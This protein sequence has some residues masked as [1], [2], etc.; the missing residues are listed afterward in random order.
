MKTDLE[1]HEINHN[2][3]RLVELT[4]EQNNSNGS[5]GN[6]T[7]SLSES[8]W[9]DPGKDKFFVRKTTLDSSNNQ[10]VIFTDI[11]GNPTSP[12][13]GPS[14]IG[15]LVPLKNT[16]YEL[17]TT[18]YYANATN[19]TNGYTIGDLISSIRIIDTNS[20]SQINT[21]VINNNTEQQCGFDIAEMEGVDSSMWN[22]QNL[23]LKEISDNTL[24]DGIL[25]NGTLQ[26]VLN[27]DL[28]TS[29]VNGWFDA[30]KFQSATIQIIN[31]SGTGSI[32]FEQ[33][34]DISVTGL[35]LATVESTL[36]NANPNIAAI[37]IAANANRIFR[38]PINSKYIRVRVSTAFTST[39][40]KA[41]GFFSTLPFSSNNVNVQQAVASML[42]ATVTQALG[43]AA[44]RWFAQ[45]SDGTNSPSIKAASVAPLATDPALVVGLNPNMVVSS[46]VINSLATTNGAVVKAT[47]ATVF[48]IT[49]S[50]TSAS[51]R[52]LK[53][54][55]ST[56]VTVGTT[57]P[58]LVIPIPASSVQNIEFGTFGMRLGTGFCVGITG[59]AAD[60]DTTVIGAGEVKVLIA[61]N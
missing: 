13:T 9:Y 22:Y 36:I 16:D 33:T 7:K 4:K 23:K 49:A 40:C 18:D 6:S 28:L 27:T 60:N 1:I 50:N 61:Y 48:S 20:G 47:P 29:S 5:T 25:V 52:Y 59:G 55:N 21:I 3:K 31:G 54:Y 38:M 15:A 32:F 53:I 56:T 2:I 57:T 17:Q 39:G 11:A 34:N 43:T 26:T 12:M 8:I 41:I 46:G 10:V 19:I 37:S 24:T 45:I 30:T 42:Q 14:S 58:A 51:L 35:P 44:T